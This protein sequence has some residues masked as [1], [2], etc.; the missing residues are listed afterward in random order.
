M[1]AIHREL[2]RK[3]N[4]VGVGRGHHYI[5]GEKIKNLITPYVVLVERKLA[6][7]ELSSS[8]LVPAA[9]A[10]I[11][12]DVREVGKIRALALRT[13]KWRP[14][15]GGVS[16]GH[17]AI[18][19]GTL[20]CLVRDASNGEILILSNNHV[21]ANSNNAYLGD[22]ILQPGP[23]DGG[24]NPDDRI[25]TL[26]RFLPI[27]FGDAGDGSE[28]PIVSSITGALNF[29]AGLCRSSWRIRGYKVFATENLADCAVARPDSPD[30]V[31][32][33]ILDIGAVKGFR[34]GLQIG[35]RVRKSGRTTG[36]NG[37]EV[38]LTNATVAVSYG[39]GLTATFVDQYVA[40]PMS[41]GGDSGSLVLDLDN[42]AA[43]LLFA[44]SDQVTIF[45]PI[46]AVIEGLGVR[47]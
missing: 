38:Q 39:E 16:I 17:Y 9:I 46:E 3:R 45:S 6:K 31:S 2:L 42:M 30:L 15:P 44:G 22:A 19:A 29:L 25:G 12:T 35:E 27:D 37:D 10:G 20:G 21:L 23:Y 5:K 47:F 43:G 11:R 24:K 4:V 14:A 18:T 32:E 34:S 36:T 8:D 1:D 33:Q 41:Q 26:L 40:G 13:D 28:C 7:E